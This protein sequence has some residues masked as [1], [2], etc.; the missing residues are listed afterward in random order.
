MNNMIETISA[1]LQPREKNCL[2]LARTFQK[3]MVEESWTQEELAQKIG[4][5]RSTL[6]NYLRLQYL[7]EY[8]QTSLG[9]GVITMGHAKALLSIEDSQRQ[10]QLYEKIIRKGL[11]VRETEKEALSPKQDDKSVDDIF[12]KPLLE[13]AQQKLGTKVTINQDGQQGSICIDY[14]NLDDLDRLL[15]VL[16][17][18]HG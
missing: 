2:E 4:I 7:P 3:L 17:G 13:E 12:I 9:A 14:Y 11:S 16:R 18:V 10:Q 5:K 15:S 1:T 8:I 6:A